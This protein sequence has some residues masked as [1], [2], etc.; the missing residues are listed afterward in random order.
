MSYEE[1]NKYISVLLTNDIVI[2]ENPVAEQLNI[3][4]THCDMLFESRSE[5]KRHRVTTHNFED[6]AI[7]YW[8][9]HR[10]ECPFCLTFVREGTGANGS[11][12]HF[13]CTPIVGN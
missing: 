3:K 7:K 12:A 8:K 13:T 11:F 9:Q 10:G 4:C 1:W 5:M 2:P 6:E